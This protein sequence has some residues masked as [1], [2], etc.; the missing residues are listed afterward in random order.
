MVKCKDVPVL[1][2]DPVVCCVYADVRFVRYADV[3]FFFFCCVEWIGSRF[4]RLYPDE[5][6]RDEQVVGAHAAPGTLT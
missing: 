3:F 1:T 4:H 2:E 6:R 5:L